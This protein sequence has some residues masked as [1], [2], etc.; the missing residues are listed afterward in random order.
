MDQSKTTDLFL[1]ADS[2]KDS[3]LRSQAKIFGLKNGTRVTFSVRDPKSS[4]HASGHAV[5]V[6]PCR[7]GDSGR[8]SGGGEGRDSGRAR[9]RSRRERRRSPSRRRKSPSRSRSP[10]RRRSPSV[11]RRSP[12][13]KKRSPSR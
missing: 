2:I 1:Y 12:S 5:D 8:G 13:P 6:E 11:K 10:P 9:S 4:R 7:D 3:K